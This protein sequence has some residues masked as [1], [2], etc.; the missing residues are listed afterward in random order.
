ME[1]IG[2]DAEKLFKLIG[3]WDTYGKSG[4]GPD[5]KQRLFQ[6]EA[7]GLGREHATGAHNKL[8]K[9]MTPQLEKMVDEYYSKDYSIPNLD[10]KRREVFDGSSTND[11]TYW[12]RTLQTSRLWFLLQNA[13]VGR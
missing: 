11:A 4:W 5:G 9:Y 6:A 13:N 2:Q 3:A 12:S 8:R 7:G 1:T 10:L